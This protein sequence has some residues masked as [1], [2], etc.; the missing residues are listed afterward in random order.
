MAVIEWPSEHFRMTLTSYHIDWTSRSA[1]VGLSG[2]EQ[3]INSGTGRWRLTFALAIEPDV[4]RLRRFE[5]LVSEM[6]GRFNSALIPLFDAYAYDN[7]VSPTQIPHSDGTWHTDGT[8]A[9]A[10][11]GVQPMVTVGAAAAGASEL[12]VGLTNPT[13][14][15]FRVGDLF[16][17]NGFLYRVVRRNAGGWVRFEPPLREAIPNGTTLET[18]PIRVRTKFATDGEGERARGLLSYGEAVTITFVEDF[19]R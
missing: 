6:R 16:T 10:G 18:S 11:D 13:L 8:G 7:S 14:P 3:I 19:D 17:V 4:M 15:S 9:M 2:H 5:A 12:T 1:G